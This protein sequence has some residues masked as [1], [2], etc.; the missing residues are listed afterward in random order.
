[1]K[2]LQEGRIIELPKFGKFMTRLMGSALINRSA[3]A[4]G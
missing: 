3:T 4:P 1:M 2:L